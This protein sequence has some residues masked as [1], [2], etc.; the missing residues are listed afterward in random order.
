MLIASDAAA[1]AVYP[2]GVELCS[3]AHYFVLSVLY[4][5]CALVIVQQARSCVRYPTADPSAV[6]G[7][8]ATG[9]SPEAR[10]SRN[11]S[12]GCARQRTRATSPGQSPHPAYLFRSANTTPRT[13]YTPAPSARYR[14]P[15][16]REEEDPT[17]R[18][19]QVHCP[20]GTSGQLQAPARPPATHASSRS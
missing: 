5:L 4:V 6:P 16:E 9:Q 14:P 10:R 1:D 11:T 20:K 13:Q 2:M 7:E 18:G 17:A 19:A 15:R 12:S 3:P 8:Q